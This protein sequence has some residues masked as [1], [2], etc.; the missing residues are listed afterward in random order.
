MCIFC[1]LYII[2]FFVVS[3]N[4]VAVLFSLHGVFRGGF[5]VL[6]AGSGCWQRVVP[7]LFRGRDCIVWVQ[8]C[9]VPEYLGAASAGRLCHCSRRRMFRGH[10]L[11]CLGVL[12]MT[13]QCSFTAAAAPHSIQYSHGNKQTDL[14]EAKGTSANLLSCSYC[15]FWL[16][17]LSS[18]DVC[19]ASPHTISD[20]IISH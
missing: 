6:A 5:G 8:I 12:N 18:C 9:I 19:G 14:T 4:L 13:I 3:E 1:V 10:T 16:P 17:L 15:L 7:V 2:Y 11:G 20:I